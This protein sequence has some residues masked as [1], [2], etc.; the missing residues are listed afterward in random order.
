MTTCMQIAGV[1]QENF[2][3]FFLWLSLLLLNQLKLDLFGIV[4]FKTVACWR[5]E[6]RS[7]ILVFTLPSRWFYPNVVHLATT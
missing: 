6:S 5:T 4:Y 1:T 3:T 7:E 2:D